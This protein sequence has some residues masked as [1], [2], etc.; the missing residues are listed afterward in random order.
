MNEALVDACLKVARLTKELE[1]AQALV[2]E[3]RRQAKEQ[4]RG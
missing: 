1:E 4:Q 3:L 2:A